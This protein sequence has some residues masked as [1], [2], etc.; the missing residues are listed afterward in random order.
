[1]NP[2]HLEGMSC[3]NVILINPVSSRTKT[4]Y[5]K[6]VNISLYRASRGTQRLAKMLP[7]RYVCFSLQA[8]RKFHFISQPRQW[9]R[10]K[11]RQ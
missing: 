2:G 4:E 3:G 6:Y 7:D 5:H 11:G 10:G 8:F 9:L 1:M